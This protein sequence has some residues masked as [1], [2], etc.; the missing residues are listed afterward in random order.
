MLVRMW[1]KGNTYSLLDG[2][3]A[4]AATMQFSVENSEK[5]ES[6]TITWPS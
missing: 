5:A 2:V 4:D 3:Q 1:E 6:K